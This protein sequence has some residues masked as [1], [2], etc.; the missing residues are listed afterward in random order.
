MTAELGLD[1]EIK[2]WLK[3]VLAVCSRMNTHYPFIS[4]EYWIMYHVIL[5]GRRPLHIMLAGDM[6]AFENL[7]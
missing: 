6:V 5:G 3:L 7:Y 4:R 1:L 2:L